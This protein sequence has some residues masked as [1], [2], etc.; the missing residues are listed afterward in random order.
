VTSPW[1]RPLSCGLSDAHQRRT[2]RL[3][4]ARRRAAAVDCRGCAGRGLAGAVQRPVTSRDA[5]SHDTARVPRLLPAGLRRPRAHHARL[6]RR[7]VALRLRGVRR[8]APRVPRPLHGEER[9]RDRA[10]ALQLHGQGRARGGAA[11]GDDADAG[12]HGRREGGLTAQADPLVRGA[13]AVPLR[14][15]AARSTARALPVER[16]HPWRGRYCGRC[17]GAGRGAGRAARCSAL[18]RRTSLRASATGV[19]W[20]RC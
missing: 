18:V 15:D 20:R 8:A 7:R 11:A 5:E 13:A 9:R 2:V 19:C 10:A 4:P 3:S 14:A 12:A 16:G 1:I 17:R 6:A